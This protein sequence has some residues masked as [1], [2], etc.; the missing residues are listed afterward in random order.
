MIRALFHTHCLILFY[1]EVGAIYYSP[2]TM[3]HLVQNMS[4]IIKLNNKECR[5]YYLLLLLVVVV[6]IIVS[7]KR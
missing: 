5:Y 1:V 7:E 4:D 2:L 6:V 3:N